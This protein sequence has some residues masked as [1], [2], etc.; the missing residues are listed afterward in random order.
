MTLS[1]SKNAAVQGTDRVFQ[2]L[3]RESLIYF[4][5]VVEIGPEMRVLGRL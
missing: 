4:L 1:E 3:I 2:R 5:Q